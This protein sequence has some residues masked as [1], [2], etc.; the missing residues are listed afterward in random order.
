MQKYFFSHLIDIQTIHI[1][2]QALELSDE[3]K[4]ELVRLA[5]DTLHYAV[6]HAVLSEL[7]EEDKKLFLRQMVHSDHASLWR[8]LNKKVRGI[9]ERVKK[10]AE[11]TAMEFRKDITESRK[12]HGVEKKAKQ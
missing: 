6:L 10:V 9:E 5:H 2:L 4:T 11:E 8:F 3:E 12:L 7:S 1:E